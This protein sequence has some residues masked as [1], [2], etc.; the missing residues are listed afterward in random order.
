MVSL[1]W[2]LLSV[3]GGI[4]VVTL[5]GMLAYVFLP[6]PFHGNDDD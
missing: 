5:L 3:L 2:V 1:G 4:G 6:D